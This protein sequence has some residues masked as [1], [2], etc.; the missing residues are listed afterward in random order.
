[1]TNL[2]NFVESELLKKQQWQ[3]ILRFKKHKKKLS[4]HVHTVIFDLSTNKQRN[5]LEDLV[6]HLSD[7]KCFTAV[8]TLFIAKSAQ[9]V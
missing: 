3:Y 6:V 7:F 2:P 1:M 9:T 8:W 4:K 5:F